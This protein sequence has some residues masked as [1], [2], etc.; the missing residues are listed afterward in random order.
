MTIDE[1]DRRCARAIGTLEE[2]AA[3]Q[4]ALLLKAAVCIAGMADA[5]V[6]AQEDRQALR[7]RVIVL[8]FQIQGFN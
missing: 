8:E 7:E 3:E 1:V 2:K 5:L 6:H 4:E